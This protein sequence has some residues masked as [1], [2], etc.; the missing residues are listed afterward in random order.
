MALSED[1][2]TAYLAGYSSV[3]AED[4]ES[5]DSYLGRLDLR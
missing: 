5:D 1:N 4:V 2:K 3:S